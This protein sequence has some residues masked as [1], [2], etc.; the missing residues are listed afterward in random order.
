MWL[1][2]VNCQLILILHQNLKAPTWHGAPDDV[3]VVG[4]EQI[5]AAQFEAE[6]VDLLANGDVMQGVWVEDVIHL[7]G[8]G[9]LAGARHLQGIA[10][11]PGLP[12]GIEEEVAVV[13]R[14]ID[15]LLAFDALQLGCL[16]LVGGDSED[17]I[18]RQRDLPIALNKRSTKVVLNAS[19][20]DHR[21]VF[22]Y[23]I[24]VETRFP[25]YP[26]LHP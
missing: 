20:K 18:P 21:H 13:A 9:S 2:T 17:V 10:Y 22:G 24:T 16:A 5:V 4:V 15:E 1:L 12:L 23:P 11:I 19:R 8:V 25:L 7:I 26:V 6:L 3:L 14:N